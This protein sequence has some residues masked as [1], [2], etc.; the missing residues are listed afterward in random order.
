MYKL[1]KRRGKKKKKRESNFKKQWMEVEHE[2]N[3]IHFCDNCTTRWIVIITQSSTAQCDTLRSIKKKKYVK[4]KKNKCLEDGLLSR[5]HQLVASWPLLK[6]VVPCVCI[7]R[8]AHDRRC[9]FRNP[10]ILRRS[11]TDE[12]HL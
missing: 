4:K 7:A 3:M 8:S 2:A 5:L 9:S 11:Q 6:C 1:L 10:L 12:S